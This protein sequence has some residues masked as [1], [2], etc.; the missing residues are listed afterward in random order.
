M[1]GLLGDCGYESSAISTCAGDVPATDPAVEVCND[2]GTCSGSPYY[3]CSCNTGYEGPNCEFQTCPTGLAWFDEPTSANVGHTTTVACS[4]RGA[5]DRSA[6]S[7]TCMDGFTGTDCALFKC[8]GSSD[9]TSAEAG[10]CYTMA[11]LATLSEDNGDLR[12]TTY[13]TTWDANKVRGCDCS[14]KHLGPF[15][16]LTDYEGFD[17]SNL[18]CPTGDDPSTP[19]GSHEVQTITCYATSGA[20]LLTFRQRT[21]ATDLI[22]DWPGFSVG[23][24]AAEVRTGILTMLKEA[25][26]APPYAYTFTDVSVEMTKVS[27]G[28]TSSTACAAGGVNIAV[29]FLT[30]LGDLP[31]MTVSNPSGT[32]SGSG[33]GTPYAGGTVTVTE[34]TKGSYENVECG[35]QG[36]CNRKKGTC[37]CLPGFDSSDGS[38]NAGQRGDCAYTLEYPNVF[39]T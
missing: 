21:A 31:L 29:T 13:T 18:A 10:T 22:N 15:A 4:A 35:N 20:F 26:G 17:C 2:R 38:G 37:A 27:D 14:R 30:E 23:D 8:P 34:T 32:L 19:T 25:T 39:E 6:G 1:G 24:T 9:C 3:T 12:G 36:I 16:T 28:S 7:C 11:D 5:C 33:S